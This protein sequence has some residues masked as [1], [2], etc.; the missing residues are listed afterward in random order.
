[1]PFVYRLGG[2]VI[3][4]S[5]NSKQFINPLDISLEYGEG[6]NPISFKT[7]FVLTMMEVIAGGKAG[8]TAKQKTIIDKCVRIIYRAYLADRNCF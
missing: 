1:A 7:E 6:E 2:E 5:A 4:I 3:K 8:L